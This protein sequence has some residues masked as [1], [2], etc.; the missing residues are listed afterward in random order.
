M[1]IPAY[2]EAM[3]RPGLEEAN[4]TGFRPKYLKI[5]YFGP[6]W[7]VLAPPVPCLLHM[8]RGDQRPLA[9]SRP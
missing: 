6:F 8:G 2:M 4:I 1:L 7:P 3:A 5:A 9:W